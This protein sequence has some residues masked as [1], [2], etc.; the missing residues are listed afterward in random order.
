MRFVVCHDTM[1]VKVVSEMHGTYISY[2][3]IRMVMIIIVLMYSYMD[4]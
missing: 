1:Q 2:F 3:D 4:V